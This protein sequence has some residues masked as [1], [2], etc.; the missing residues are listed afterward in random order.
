MPG[1]LIRRALCLRVCPLCREAS[2]AEG[3]CAF[4]DA[5]LEAASLCHPRFR[6]G[7][8]VGVG[9]N[10]DAA[11]SWLE[12]AAVFSYEYDAV[13]RLLFY[14]KQNADACAFHEAALYLARAV[15]SFG[16]DEKTLYVNV[17]RSRA[18]K[19]RYGFDQGAL[20]A[21]AAAR[22]SENAVF[23]PRLIRRRFGRP[24]KSLTAA[25]RAENQRGRFSVRR[26]LLCPFPEPK[27][28]ILIDDV[29]TTGASVLACANALRTLYPN[30]H[31]VAAAL[32]HTPAPGKTTKE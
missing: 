25:E 3:I 24:Q 12:C 11:V 19:R 26:P 15:T 20:L 23:A 28:I 18:G 8:G 29:I 7:M 5:A 6:V 14:L 13:R 17:P 2:G 1:R 27:R 22:L 30:A 4:C 21:S 10:P 31:I 16:T 9:A 32:A